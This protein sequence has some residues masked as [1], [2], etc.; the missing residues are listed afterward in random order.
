M[1]SD[2]KESD[3]VLHFMNPFEIHRAL[4]HMSDPVTLT[5]TFE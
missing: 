3:S 2:P 5:D 1:T 4:I